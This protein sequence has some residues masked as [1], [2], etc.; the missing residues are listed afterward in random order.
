[1][2]RR[3]S[4]PQWK[5]GPSRNE[6]TDSEH[7]IDPEPVNY[8][9]DGVGR[10]EAERVDGEPLCAVREAYVCCRDGCDAT[11]QK[12]H[13]YAL[14]DVSKRVRKAASHAIEHTDNPSDEDVVEYLATHVTTVDYDEGP[15][16]AFEFGEETLGSLHAHFTNASGFSGPC[17]GRAEPSPDINA[18]RYDL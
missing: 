3:L 5:S 9:H 14:T 12:S 1:M 18:H 6:P 13:V 4:D 15:I 11:P 16:L 7:A 8:D 10:D 17:Y 2:A